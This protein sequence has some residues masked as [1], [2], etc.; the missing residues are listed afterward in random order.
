MDSTRRGFLSAGAFAGVG[1]GLGVAGDRL[2]AGDGARRSADRA[3][4]EFYGGHQAGI[5]TRSQEHL[6]FAAFDLVSDALIDLRGLLERWSAAA[7]LLVQGRPVGA[8]ATGNAPPVDTGEA[9]GLEPSSVTI[10]FGLGP[11]VFVRGG[12]DRLGL[13]ALRP[14]ALAALPAFPGEALE[15]AVK[16]G[17]L[18]R[19]RQLWLPAHLDYER[20]GGADGAFADFNEEING[21]PLSLQGG[22]T[23]PYFTGF[24]ALEY[25]LWGGQTTSELSPTAVALGQAVHSLIAQFP[26]IALVPGDLALSTY[27]ILE[28]TLQYEMTGETDEGSNTNLATAWANVEGTEMAL[29]ALGP[30]LRQSGPGVLPRL[31]QG[32]VAMA[33]AFKAYEASGGTWEPLQ[34]LSTLQH[35]SLDGQLGALLEELSVVPELLQPLQP[36]SSS[37]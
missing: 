34:Y 8:L 16:L 22:V 18:S 33:A 1:A 11:G 27:Q 9:V 15:S 13:A 6:Q 3:M 30:A 7:A 36:V 23:S 12:R 31:Q 20:L 25:G 24:L 35:E 4:V 32:L 5:A 17:Q 21:T 10:T 29:N 28:N 37:S 19:A 26:H 14:A 2:T